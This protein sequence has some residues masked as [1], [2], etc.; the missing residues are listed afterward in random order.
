MKVL[1]LSAIL[2]LGLVLLGCIGGS[3]PAPSPTE[4]PTAI[5]TAVPTPPPT[6]TPQPNVCRSAC[7]DGTT[8]E[9]GQ[10]CAIQI[11]NVCSVRSNFETNMTVESLPDARDA[12]N[13][14]AD[15]MRAHGLSDSN[16]AV[17]WEFKQAVYLGVYQNSSYW[18]VLFHYSTKESA[19][20]NAQVQ[21][22]EKGE[23]VNLLR[24][25]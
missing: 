6:P 18:A 10:E 1:A 13:K 5:P 22:G 24:C 23:I 4:I 20:G 12:F 21:V 2:F 14:Y 8:V 15:Y 11:Q 25:A 17:D 3:Q 9:R 7:P 19:E 16:N